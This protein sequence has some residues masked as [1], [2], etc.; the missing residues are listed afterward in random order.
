MNSKQSS[1]RREKPQKDPIQVDETPAS[2]DA[3][4]GRAMDVLSGF[5]SSVNLFVPPG[6]LC[7][8]LD[9][10]LNMYKAHFR[11]LLRAVANTAFDDVPMHLIHFWSQMPDH[12]SPILDNEFVANL[13]ETCDN[14]FYEVRFAS[15]LRVDP[16]DSCDCLM[17][18][19]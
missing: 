7:L 6:I 13:I 17:T 8:K 5:P 1:V 2:E 19:D 3:R 12:L 10:F 14:L 15:Y 11:N 16:V 4:L 18:H 9:S